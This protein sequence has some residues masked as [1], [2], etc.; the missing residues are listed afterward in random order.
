MDGLIDVEVNSGMT[1]TSER[2][3]ESVWY[4]TCNLQR[5][6]YNSETGHG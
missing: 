1:A 4:V 3:V 2:E 6:H 5:L